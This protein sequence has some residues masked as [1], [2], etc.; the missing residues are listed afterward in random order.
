MKQIFMF[1]CAGFFSLGVSAQHF[2]IGLDY[3]ML[4]GGMVEDDSGNPLTYS[5]SAEVSSNSPVLCLNYTYPINDDM[6]LVSSV[7]YSLGFGIMPIKSS[8]SYS[9]SSSLS[10]NAGMGLYMI[11]DSIYSPEA[12]AEGDVDADGNALSWKGTGNEFGMSLG[13]KYHM[14]KIGVGLSY[15]V[16]RTEEWKDLNSMTISL[17]YAFGGGSI[18]QS[19]ERQD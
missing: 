2:G 7:G 18:A 6:S 11:S 15:E 12:S 19:V 1:L 13:L 4:S 5:D 9:L 16:I 3:M 17:S 14:N 8:L 10:I